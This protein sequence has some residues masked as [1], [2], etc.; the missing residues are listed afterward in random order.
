[1]SIKAKLIAIV[2]LMTLFLLFIG[3]MGMR[4]TDS[5]HNSLGTVYQDRV[6]PL[7][8]LKLIADAYAVSVIDAVN[9]A[10]AGLMSAEELRAELTSASAL[11]ASEWQAYSATQLTPEEAQL[12]DEARVLFQKADAAMARLGRFAANLSG[13]ISGQLDDFDGELYQDIDPISNKIGELISLQL[14]VARAEFDASEAVY[15]EVRTFSTGLMIAG[16]LLAIAAIWVLFRFVISPLQQALRLANA[17]ASGDLNNQIDRSGKDEAGKLLSALGQVQDAVSAIIHGQQDMARA[18]REGRVSAVLEP[19]QFDGAYADIASEVNAL[20]ACHLDVENKL[21]AVSREYAKGNFS[22]DMDALPGEQAAITEALAEVKAAL[23]G[24]S[25][26]IKQMAASGA[27][28]DFS[29][30]V[31]ASGYQYLFRETIEDLNRL[32]A[33]CDKGFG[34]IRRV[35]EAL[36]DGD[37]SQSIEAQYPGVFGAAAQSVN[38]TLT[39]LRQTLGEVDTMVAAACQ[40][41][42]GKRMAEQGLAGYRLRLAGQLNS[43]SAV[44]ES[45]LKEINAVVSALSTGRLDRR[46]EGSYPGLFGATQAGVNGTVDALADF[47][48]DIDTM[49]NATARHGDFSGQIPIEGRSGFLLELSTRLNE[50]ARVTRDGLTQVKHIASAIADG[51]LTTKASGQFPGL[52]GETLSAL[53]GTVVRLSNMVGE[54]QDAAATLQVSARE[55][56]SGNMDLSNRTEAQAH[57][58]EETVANF[59]SLSDS[60]GANTDNAVRAAGLAS[61]SAG[62]ASLGAKIVADVENTM[63]NIGETSAQIANITGMIDSIAFQ[64]NI[65]ALNAAVEAARAGDSGRGFGVVAAEVRSLASRSAEAAREIREVIDAAASRIAAGNEQAAKAGRAMKEI[66]DSVQAVAGLLEQIASSS[67]RQGQGMV[68]VRGAIDQIDSVTQHN[69]ALVEE[70]TAAAASM[71][72][73]VERLAKLMSVFKLEATQKAGTRLASVP[74]GRLA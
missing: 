39:S 45:G 24:I 25:R 15:A 26:N 18:H 43:L 23:L 73:Q 47:V 34:D 22:V 56:A 48:N 58:V 65:L 68:Q 17:V 61:A 69:A 59:R 11:I 27:D 57:S 32:L 4:G 28:G 60:I 3:A 38:R 19:S 50:L 29:C 14:D 66:D 16:G 40:G 64:T 6:V 1:M 2:A 12:A 54:I 52:F 9:K 63:S 30:R 36:S 71:Q 35:T 31:D 41:D 46:M 20:V 53:D 67:Q 13:D 5:M 74:A 42:F 51:E 10:N 33:T 7:K 70:A 37:L 62:Q 49:V 44:T 8:Q 72:S 55:I 21:V